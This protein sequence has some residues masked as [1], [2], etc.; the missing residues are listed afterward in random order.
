LDLS[1]PVAL[2]AHRSGTDRLV[3]PEETL[4][5]V[6]RF[7]PVMGITRVADITGLD[8]IG[9]PIVLAHRPNSRHIVVTQGKGLDLAAS[10]ASAVME[11]IEAYTAERIVQPLILGSV[12]DAAGLPAGALLSGLLAT[13]APIRAVFALVAAGA[14]AATALAGWAC[15]RSGPLAAVAIPADTN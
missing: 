6:R 8:T 2:K 15:L 7:F 5:N 3:A 1:R 10:K 11:S 9:I 4:E 14:V 13:V 12:N